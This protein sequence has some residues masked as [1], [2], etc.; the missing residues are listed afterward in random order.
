VVNEINALETA[1]K[2]L[3]DRLGEMA[4]S[5]AVMNNNVNRQAKVIDK[6]VASFDKLTVFI[7]RTNENDKKIS[8]LFKKVDFLQKRW[9]HQM[10]K[11]LYG[12]AS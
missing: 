4:K 9:H 5:L 10:G 8:A 7:E 2:E 6:L 12:W 11:K 1:I 3:D